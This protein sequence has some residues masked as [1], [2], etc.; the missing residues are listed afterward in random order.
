MQELADR[1]HIPLPQLKNELKQAVKYG[2]IQEQKQ[3]KQ[4]LYRINLVEEVLA[5][6]GVIFRL[7][8]DFFDKL[9]QK[10]DRL[11]KVVFVA[12]MGIL[13]QRENDRIDLFMVADDLNEKKFDNCISEIEIELAQEL[14]YT[15]LSSQDFQYR[16]NMFDKFVLDILEN[17]N[18]RVLI[19]KLVISLDN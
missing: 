10:L 19:D 14:R 18:T 15:L 6:E 3:D 11:G 12:V 16:K 2:L 8:E 4:S 7:S 1:T 5:L 17:S 13:L 9:S